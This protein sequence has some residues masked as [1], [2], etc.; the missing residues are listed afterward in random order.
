M[1]PSALLA[2]AAVVFVAGCSSNKN[3]QTGRSPANGYYGPMMGPMMRGRRAPSSE[4]RFKT[5]GQRIYYTATS[6]SGEP[7]TTS[8]GPHWFEMH[9]GS[10]VDCHGPGGIGGYE[11]PMTN[12]VAPNITYSA[13]TSKKHETHGEQHPP[14]TDALIKRA[15][16]KG[17]DPAG[18]PLS[19]AMP[20]WNMSKGDLNDLIAYLKTLGSTRNAQTEE[21]R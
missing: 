14:Y 11:V 18:H 17:V 6:S 15:V 3:S 7:I 16:T 8:G 10:C 13:L 20:R 1:R 4:Q 9:G 12:V 5:N 19:Y 2:V 21:D